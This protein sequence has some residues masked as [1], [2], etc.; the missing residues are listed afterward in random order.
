MFNTA[1]HPRWREAV[2]QTW[3][4]L[5]RYYQIRGDSQCATTIRLHCDPSFSAAQLKRIGQAI[6]HFEPVL[7]LFMPD[8]AGTE[9]VCKRNWRDNPFLR[10]DNLTQAG[11]IAFIER[12]PNIQVDRVG[13]SPENWVTILMGHDTVWDGTRYVW[14]LQNRQTNVTTFCKP[15]VCERAEDAIHWSDLVLSFIRAALACPT[16]ARLQRIAM[17][18]FGLRYFLSNDLGN[19]R[20]RLVAGVWWHVDMSSGQLVVRQN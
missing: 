7:D 12:I 18:P 20:R 3:S 11:S 6:I 16:P 15:V 2:N 4:Y 13:P 1:E 10:R 17:N 8:R 5:T 9:I 14:Y 19:T